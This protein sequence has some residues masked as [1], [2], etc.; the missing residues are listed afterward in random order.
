M[1]LG[2]SSERRPEAKESL[3]RDSVW[4][5]L[6]GELDETDYYRPKNRTTPKGERVDDENFAQIIASNDLA[7]VGDE[8]DASRQSRSQ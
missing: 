5:A 1:L 6:K 8:P 7:I 3:E 4:K 2:G